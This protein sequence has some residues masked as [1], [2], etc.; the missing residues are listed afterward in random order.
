L[1]VE[2]TILLWLKKHDLSTAEITFTIIAG[3]AIAGG[4]YGEYHFG[5]RASAGALTLEDI[6]EGRVAA[7]NKE[8]AQARKEA[9]E[10]LALIQPRDL[11]EDQ[12][13]KIGESV[14]AFSGRRV[15]LLITWYRFDIEGG[16]LSQEIKSGLEFGK[17]KVVVAPGDLERYVEMPEAHLSSSAGFPPTAMSGVRI[18]SGRNSRPFADS[19]KNSLESQGKFMVSIDPLA[20]IV[21]RQSVDDVLYIFVGMKPIPVIK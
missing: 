14:R 7:L 19:L 17:V 21:G 16:R 5:S 12:Q 2:Y 13:R 10:L 18:F 15:P 20:P 1:L 4:V 9:A 11:S 3:I 6:S 8:A